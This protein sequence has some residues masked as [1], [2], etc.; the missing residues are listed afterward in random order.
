M[1]ADTDPTFAGANNVIIIELE[2]DDGSSADG[3]CAFDVDAAIDP[4][5]VIG[6]CLRAGI[7]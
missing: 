7:E 4:L 2:G 1:P 5:E 3:G 6:P